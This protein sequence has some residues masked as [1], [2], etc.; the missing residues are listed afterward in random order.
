M[1]MP[2]GFNVKDEERWKSTGC[3][4]NQNSAKDQSWS[5]LQMVHIVAYLTVLG[6][7]GFITG[8][9]WYV[10]GECL[11]YQEC[12]FAF[13]TWTPPLITCNI[14][15]MKCE[16]GGCCLQILTIMYVSD[17][18]GPG[19]WVFTHIISTLWKIACWEFGTTPNILQGFQGDCTS[20]RKVWKVQ[21]KNFIFII[22]FPFICGKCCYRSWHT[23]EDD[24]KWRDASDRCWT[25]PKLTISFS[26]GKS[27]EYRS[28]HILWFQ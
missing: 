6:E 5:V 7:L 22:F 15:I 10:S 21:K 28:H 23:W 16:I 26:P 18:W 4:L 27:Q 2:T 9:G 19:L 1:Q 20:N 11:E 14:E 3:F 25:P 13:D 8:V 24:P 17:W 12:A